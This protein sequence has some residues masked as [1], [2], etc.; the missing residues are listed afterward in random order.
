MTKEEQLKYIEENIPLESHFHSSRKMRH[1]F[2]Q[3][4]ETEIQ[5]Y[6]LGFFAADGG[7]DEKRKT[8]RIQLS[9][10][11]F[12]TV[13]LFRDVIAPTARTFRVEGK[14]IKGRNGKMY[15]RKDCYGVDI[16]STILC[17]SLNKLGFGYR[18]TW[19]NTSLPNLNLDLIKHFIRGYFDGDGSVYDCYVK[20]D[21]KYKKNERIRIYWTVVSKSKQIL[22]DIQNIFLTVG[23]KSSIC[24][25]KRDKIY[26]LSCPMSQLSKIYD[27]LYED[28]HFYMKRKY[29]KMCYYVNTEVTQLIAKHCNAQKVNDI[30]S[31]NP[32]TSAGHPIDEGEN[33]C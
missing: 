4:I 8:M 10:D 25:T 1:T 3:N 14:E 15:I 20:P 26:Q 16:N 17:D 7:L 12:E 32:S 28:S 11:D 27:F 19:E 31:N 23:I 33:I 21:Q 13:N 6:L 5:A 9:E 18:K 24:F 30:E 2:F 29:D 22:E